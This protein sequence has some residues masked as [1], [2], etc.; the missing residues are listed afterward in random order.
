MVPHASTP[1]GKQPNSAQSSAATK[2]AEQQRQPFRL[3]SQIRVF[4]RNLRRRLPV[5]VALLASPIL[6]AGCVT[7]GTTATTTRALCEPWRAIS[8]SGKRDSSQTVREIRVHNRTGQN[9]RCWK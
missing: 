5:A 7:T 8:Y 4:V 3:P 1:N 2:L 9:L 6:L